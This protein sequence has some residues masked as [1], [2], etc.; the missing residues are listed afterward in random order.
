MSSKPTPLREMEI[1]DLLESIN[2]E[3]CFECQEMGYCAADLEKLDDFLI[4]EVLE[5]WDL[6]LSQKKAIVIEF[7]LDYDALYKFYLI[8]GGLYE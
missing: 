2:V 3:W 1:D 6:S 8:K 5:T 7:E 4:E